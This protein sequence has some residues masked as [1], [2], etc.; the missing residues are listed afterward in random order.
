MKPHVFTRTTSAS[1]DSSASCQPPSSSRAASS[2]ESTS[3]RAQP[4]VTILTRRVAEPGF[5]WLDDTPADYGNPADASAP[6]RTSHRHDPL[7]S[8]QLTPAPKPMPTRT[9][10][11]HGPEA[12]TDPGP[13]G[14]ARL[15]LPA[16]PCKPSEST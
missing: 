13:A 10:G 14:T 15:S 1:C 3:F 5:S 9:R 4:R 7:A 2:S 12:S 8:K 11:Q 6:A 16:L